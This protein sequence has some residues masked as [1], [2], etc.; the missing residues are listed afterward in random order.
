[1][2]NKNI[3]I[4][5]L[6]FNTEK[7]ILKVLNDLKVLKYPMVV[8]D[9]FSND[10][11]LNIV[12]EFIK[13]NPNTQCEVI[14]NSSNEGAG[15]SCRILIK[16]CKDSGYKYIVKVDG[17]D[18]FETGDIK[19]IILKLESEKYDFI[20]SN[21]FWSGGITG[22]IPKIRYFGNLIATQFLHFATG[23]NRIYDPLNGL[24]GVNTEIYENLNNK[25][26]PKRYGYP[27]YITCQAILNNYRS[28][29]INNQIK[30]SDQES[31]IKPLK[32]LINLIKQT[33]FFNRRK[34]QF[35]KI[36]YK[37]H[38]SL[39][40]E[41]IFKFFLIIDMLLILRFVLGYF[42]NIP[43]LQTNIAG[44]G[45]LVVIFSALTFLIYSI[46]FNLENEYRKEYIFLDE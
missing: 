28:L 10:K 7:Y 26:Y 12:N 32:L 16:H 29:Q 6:S 30:Y 45:I 15:Q 31:S 43:M 4:G 36:N 11:S 17:D 5:I 19:S 18:Q 8:I 27:F 9:D 13:Q 20:K 39:F 24:F 3:A 37:L 38:K 42:T 22:N 41:I 21:R 40:Y 34:Y 1:M 46:S 35:K 25:K 2:T 23:T 33:L 14:E 44:W